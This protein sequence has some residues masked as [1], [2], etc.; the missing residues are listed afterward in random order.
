MPEPSTPFFTPF[1]GRSE[2]Y[3]F[4]NRIGTCAYDHSLN[5]DQARPAKFLP[6][7]KED[8]V[9][10]IPVVMYPG[11]IVGV[12]NT[13]DH[14]ALSAF[15]DEKPGILVPA[16]ASAAGYEIVTTSIDVN[17]GRYG[18]I[19][20]ADGTGSSLLSAA[21]TSTVTVAQ[22]IPLGVVQEPVWCE[23][24]QLQFRNLRYQTKINVLTRGRQLRIPC[25]TAEEVLIQPGDLVQVS[26]TAGDHDPTV[27]ATSYP[28]RWKRFDPTGATVAMV[29]F[30]V[31]RCV[32]RRRI[33]TGT[34]ATV[35]SADL[36]ANVTLTNVNS[37]QDYDTLARVQTVPGLGLQGSATQGAL[38]SQTFALSDGSGDYWEIDVSIGVIGV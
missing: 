6:R 2:R 5:L 14:S 4:W 1:G 22:T 15:T 18:S 12:L 37:D 25:M 24:T 13:R 28:G 20:D 19:Y 26:D 3:P 31:G 8:E 35:L 16:H 23:A 30:I 34:A 17:S 29:P 7:I 33:A 38:A 10:Q 9:R 36:A 11:T 27:P 21:G 32:D